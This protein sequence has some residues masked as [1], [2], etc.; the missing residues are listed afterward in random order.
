MNLRA[1]REYTEYVIALD[2]RAS[3]GLFLGIRFCVFFGGGDYHVGRQS[4]TMQYQF[5]E[6][7][8]AEVFPCMDNKGVGPLSS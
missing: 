5:Q 3:M 8:H 6:R 1:Q 7:V 4:L 2:S